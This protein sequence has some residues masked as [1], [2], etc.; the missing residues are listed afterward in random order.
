MPGWKFAFRLSR[1]AVKAATPPGT[2]LL[3]EHSASL[4][5]NGQAVVRFPVPT[6]DPADPLNW[7]QWRKVMCMVTVSYYAFVANYISSSVAP[8]LALWEHS[9]PQDPRSMQDLIQLV[10]F[11]VL[12]LGL[13]NI[14]WVPLANIFG[15]R[16]IL[17]LST[18][19]LAIAS[20]CGMGL[21][22][23]KMTMMV[24]ILQGL[25]SSA[26][27]TVT[28]AVV[29]DLFFV[30]ERGGWMALY[31]ASLASG[32]VVGGITG[33]YIAFELGWVQQFWIATGL[34]SIA[35]LLTVLFVPETMF[36]RKV[37]LPVERPVPRVPGFTP[38]PLPAPGRPYRSATRRTTL[39]T[40]PAINFSLPRRLWQK[41]FAHDGIG[42]AW[43]RY[44]SSS[45]INL[46]AT[47]SG[48]A[49][50]YRI[51]VAPAP[52]DLNLQPPAP[53]TTITAKHYAP[54]TFRRS[55]FSIK[56][57]PY[58]G[59]VLRQFKKPWTTL[60]LPATWII[61]LQYGGLVG[62][63]AVISTVGP[64]VL[65]RPPYRWG[66][67]TGLLF[68]GA[69]VGILFG[70]LYTGLL[71]DWMLTYVARGQ[72]HGY[73]EPEARV[74]IMVPSLVVG[75][76]GL[77]VFGACA[78]SPGS[79]VW[80]GLEFAYGMVAFA[81]AQAPSIWFNYLIDSSRADIKIQAPPQ[82]LIATHLGI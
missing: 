45:S 50:P 31:T 38:R 76:C 44:R 14:I 67:H 9:F 32:S 52:S 18:A 51:W 10:S 79:Y 49:R 66:E 22:G 42:Q 15:R 43:Y 75:T 19:L 3:I 12:V 80:I 77:A 47:A 37:I 28:P 29:G 21:T 16:L 61:M 27:E 62:G 82:V 81:L 71:A 73:A 68:V 26:S 8:A 41:P 53:H 57:G 17:N 54:Y 23:Y 56:P 40:L 70:A 58:H 59:D 69:L 13:G 4:P 20:G 39:M 1:E 46:P 48:P 34:S 55:L 72:D 74:G 78:Q 36:Q 6:A 2:V 11:N 5:E 7:P 64:Q 24:R 65:A 30:H 35:F 60:Y 63:V 25:G 33:G